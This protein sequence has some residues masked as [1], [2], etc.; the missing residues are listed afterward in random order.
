MAYKMKGFSGF[1]NSPIKQTTDPKKK[2]ETSL[3][4]AKRGLGLTKEQLAEERATALRRN[5]EERR[6]QQESVK[7]YEAKRKRKNIP[8]SER[9][10]FWQRWFD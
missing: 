1:G 10:F 2:K 4:K 8:K 5:A 9:P 6:K 3:E 7:K